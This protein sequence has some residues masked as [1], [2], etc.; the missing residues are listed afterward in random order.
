[1]PLPSPETGRLSAIARPRL[2]LWRVGARPGAADHDMRQRAGRRAQP[3]ADAR[4]VWQPVLT[5]ADASYFKEL[6]LAMPHLEC[7]AAVR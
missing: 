3:G 1:V 2:R 7:R 6:A 4:A 5:G